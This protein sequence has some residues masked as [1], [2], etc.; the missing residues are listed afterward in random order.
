[1]VSPHALAGPSALAAVSR[2]R[3]RRHPD[4]AGRGRGRDRRH[5]T[6]CGEHDVSGH[7]ARSCPPP[8]R[9]A[10]DGPPGIAVVVQSGAEPEL[11]VAGTAVVGRD[12]P[13]TLDDHTRV[14]SVAKAY[15]G[16]T[17]LALVSAGTLGLDSTIGDRLP[18]LP[19]AWARITLAQLL[20]HTSG[21]A[22][23]SHSKAFRAG[24]GREPPG[25][26]AARRPGEYVADDPLLFPPGTRYHYSNTDNIVVGLMVRGGDGRHVPRASCGRSSRAARP[27]RRPR[28]RRASTSRTPTST[29]TTSRVRRPPRT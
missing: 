14:A 18:Q 13:A 11:H 5:G 9:H 28:C 1:M 19:S 10:R 16:A 15:S 12:L 21:L 4:P 2:V 20:Q 6:R 7:R 8:L 26:A 27:R 29:A 22:D 25:S 23:F 3:T 24:P 17:A